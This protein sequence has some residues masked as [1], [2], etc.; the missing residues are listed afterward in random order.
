MLIRAWRRLPP[1][2]HMPS[3]E[4]GPPDCQVWEPRS[5]HLAHI[6]W[7]NRSWASALAGFL[8]KPWAL[9]EDDRDTGRRCTQGRTL[10]G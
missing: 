5:F 6:D 8:L 3:W 1:H 4:G 9:H 2:L 10:I 7:A